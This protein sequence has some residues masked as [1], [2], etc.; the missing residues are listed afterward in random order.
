MTHTAHS[1]YG[2]FIAVMNAVIATAHITQRGFT[3]V[4]SCL[5][6]GATVDVIGDAHARDTVNV[7]PM[8]TLAQL[9]TASDTVT[10]ERTGDCEMTEG[11]TVKGGWIL[12]GMYSRPA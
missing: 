10:I 9:E 6:S 12:P 8:H 5:D 4:A 7:T 2:M 3:S 11:L 1:I